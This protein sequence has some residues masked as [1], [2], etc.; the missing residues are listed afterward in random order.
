MKEN[1]IFI[2]LF[3]LNFFILLSYII[4]IPFF[5]NEAEKKGL[6]TTIIGII[7]GTYAIGGYF[8]TLIIGYILKKFSI[9][10]VIFFGNSLITIASFLFGFIYYFN[11]TL[12]AVSSCILR[13]VQGFGV[14][15]VSTVLDHTIIVIYPEE[16]QLTSKYAI[17]EIGAGLGFFIGPSLGSLFYM[18]IY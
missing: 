10:K 2:L 16:N 14:T 11:Y 9:T 5:P 8:A 7:L 17:L 12:F 13:F 6:S 3:T 1:V 15:I 4:L 18:V